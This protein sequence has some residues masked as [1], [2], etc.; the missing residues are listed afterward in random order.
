MTCFP[1]KKSRRTKDNFKYVGT[2]LRQQFF[3]FN[4]VNACASA[5]CGN[6]NAPMRILCELEPLMVFTVRFKL[7][8]VNERVGCFA[9]K[10]S[11]C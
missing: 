9:K 1:T 7:A 10:S 6:W 4:I 5:S 11:T 2:Y 3:H 8:M